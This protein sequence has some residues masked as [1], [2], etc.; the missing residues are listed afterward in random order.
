[1][2]SDDKALKLYDG[3]FHD[4]LNDVGRERVLSD[5]QEWLLARSDDAS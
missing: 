5:V 1:V 3:Y 4:L 2:G